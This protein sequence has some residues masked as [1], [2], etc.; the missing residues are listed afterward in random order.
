M[1]GPIILFLLPIALWRAVG[2]TGYRPSP[3]EPWC[4]SPPARA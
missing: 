2:I 4:D 3:T 1:R